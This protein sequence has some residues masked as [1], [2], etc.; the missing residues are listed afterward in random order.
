MSQA[1][2]LVDFNTGINQAVLNPLPIL[3]ASFHRR[4]SNKISVFSFHNHVLQGPYLRYVIRPIR[5]SEVGKYRLV[6]VQGTNRGRL[7]S[8]RLDS[9]SEIETIILPQQ[10]KGS[11]PT[12]YVINV[13]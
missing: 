3:E 6:L 2:A 9:S 10:T 5:P 8:L 7:S 1:E 13:R 11:W 4:N 12:S